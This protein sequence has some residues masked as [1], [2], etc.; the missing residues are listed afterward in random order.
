V[1]VY[2]GDELVAQSESFPRTILTDE[3]AVE[4]LALAGVLSHPDYRGRGLGRRVIEPVFG[5][6]DS[7]EFPF[8]F[9]QTP[10][11]EFYDYLGCVSVED[12]F[13]NGH[14]KSRREEALFWEDHVMVYPSD[15]PWFKGPIDLNGPAY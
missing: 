3:G 4:I 14:L 1:L 11:P 9:F 10:V 13:F 12:T 8:C 7:G 2:E 6:I 5:R 15:R